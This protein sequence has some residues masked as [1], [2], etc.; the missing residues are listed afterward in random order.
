M[1]LWLHRLAAAFILAFEA[2]ACLASVI[3]LML[4]S[5][6]PFYADVL[7]V[8]P[9]AWVWAAMFAGACALAVAASWVKGIFDKRLPS[10]F[11]G[12]PHHAH[13]SGW[14]FVWIVVVA[15]GIIAL[16]T[17]ASASN[18][19]R[20]VINTD[21]GIGIMV[22]LAVAFV[23]AALVPT[24]SIADR[25]SGVLQFLGGFVRPFGRFLSIVDSI[26]VIAVAG[27]AGATQNSVFIRYVMLF[28]TLGS[29]AAMGYWLEPP[30]GLL[31]L[32]WGFLVAIAGRRAPA[33]SAA[34]RSDAGVLAG[35]IGS[36]ARHGTS[37][38][39]LRVC[40]RAVASGSGRRRQPRWSPCGDP[41]G[42]PGR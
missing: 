21:W 41:R 24:V 19:N 35:R 1:G 28:R 3:L 5:A 16:A 20:A 36:P 23:A 25:A 30:W 14:T 42:N 33:G 29:C 32:G 13:I 38:R 15:S 22:V 9:T 8:W 11:G 18:D 10:R 27:A 2:L 40:R 6:A 17:W 12:E 39:G 26:L 7:P 31:P 4:L 34:A 37:G